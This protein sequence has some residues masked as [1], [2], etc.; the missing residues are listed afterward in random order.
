MY[1]L[2]LLFGQTCSVLFPELCPSLQ[3][4]VAVVSES[5]LF[6]VSRLQTRLPSLVCLSL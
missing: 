1:C 6:F 2:S 4:S 3:E 5:M